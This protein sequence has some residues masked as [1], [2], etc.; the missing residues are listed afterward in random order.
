MYKR[1]LCYTLCREDNCRLTL[2]SLW[3]SSRYLT[4][5]RVCLVKYWSLVCRDSGLSSALPDLSHRDSTFCWSVSSLQSN[6]IACVRPPIY[7]VKDEISCYWLL[8]WVQ[9]IV[10]ARVKRRELC[11]LWLQSAGSEFPA[12]SVGGKLSNNFWWTM[13][14][15][16]QL[17]KRNQ[18]VP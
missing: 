11:C 1:K 15:T 18:T 5:G 3:L 2:D 6:S 17:R 10:H 4:T 13:G 8:L 16:E 7:Q 9:A 12:Y 14:W